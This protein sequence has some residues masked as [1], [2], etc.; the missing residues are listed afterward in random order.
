[1][2]KFGGIS[3]PMSTRSLQCIHATPASVESMQESSAALV[4]SLPHSPPTI[5][6]CLLQLR[7]ER[8]FSQQASTEADFIYLTYICI[9]IYMYIYNI[10]TNMYSI[11]MYLLS[12]PSYATRKYATKLRLKPNFVKAL[13]IHPKA[14]P[15]IAA[16]GPG[17]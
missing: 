7:Q 6:S 2:W 5:V 12:L 8:V 16:F 9:Y 11:S 1:M 15:S 10:N 17:H 13:D 14:Q 3:R 4:Q